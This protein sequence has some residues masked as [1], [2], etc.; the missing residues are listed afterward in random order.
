MK[1]IH[2]EVTQL[3]VRESVSACQLLQFLGKPNAASQVML[4]APL[5]YR[6][7]QKDLQV[8][9]DYENLVRLSKDSREELDWWQHHLAHW[10][11]K[12]VIQRQTQ[13]AI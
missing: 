4:V 5:F 2:K 11:G 10:N 13:I 9:Q 3:L 12:T 7:L 8:A 1:Q 6:A